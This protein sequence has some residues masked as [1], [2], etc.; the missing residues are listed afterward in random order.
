MRINEE[1]SKV[2][3]DKS[4]LDIGGLWGTVNERV[5]VAA[6]AG[7]KF[8]AMADIQPLNH[9][10]W[11]RFFARLTD[12]GVTCDKIFSQDL[13]NKEFA[14]TVGTFN[15]VHCSGIIYHIPNPFHAI[16]QI[17]SVAKQEAFINTTVIPSEI[18]TE[19]GELH[20]PLGAALFVPA[21]QSDQK[22]SWRNILHKLGQKRL[23]V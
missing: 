8:T 15:I 6:K 18:K 1:I 2:V 10:L 16:D 3:G 19:S 17:L 11:D 22:I 14:S 7:A 20:V 5:S 23:L 4:F 21:M 12:E 13:L 9:Q